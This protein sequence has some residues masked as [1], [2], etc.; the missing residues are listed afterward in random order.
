MELLHSYVRLSSV[1]VI[2]GHPGNSHARWS[3]LCCALFS[4]Q[5]EEFGRTPSIWARCDLAQVARREP[6]SVDCSVFISLCSLSSI[7]QPDPFS[8]LYLYYVLVRLLLNN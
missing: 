6:I 1:G 5:S 2:T 7:G 3:V 8:A 4:V